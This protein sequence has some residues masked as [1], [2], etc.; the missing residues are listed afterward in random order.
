LNII[1]KN[2]SFEYGMQSCPMKPQELSMCLSPLHH[3]CLWLYHLTIFSGGWSIKVNRNQYKGLGKSHSF[4]CLYKNFFLLNTTEC[5]HLCFCASLES[6]MN[7]DNA[8][9]AHPA[10]WNSECNSQLSHFCCSILKFGENPWLLSLT[11]L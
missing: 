9:E 10:Q 6:S 1:K 5:L 4:F 7:H 11:A 2:T 8:I 3:C